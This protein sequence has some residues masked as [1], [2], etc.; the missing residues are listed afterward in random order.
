MAQQLVAIEILHEVLMAEADEAEK[1]A[2]PAEGDQGSADLEVRRLGGGPPVER[3]LKGGGNRAAQPV[4]S[5]QA[6][7]A[8]V[9]LQNALQKQQQ[10]LQMMSTI[11][12]QLHDAATAVIRKIGG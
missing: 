12:K 3:P 8:N 9:D 10:A 1:P 2:A 6:Q 11:S 5:D 7:L 4:G